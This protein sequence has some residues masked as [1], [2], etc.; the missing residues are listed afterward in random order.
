PTGPVQIGVTSWGPEVM[1]GDCGVKHLPQVP[2]RVSSFAAFINSKHPVIEPYAKRRNAVPKIVGLPHIG[3]TVTC[4][5][6]ELV[7]DGIKMSYS[8]QLAKGGK[9]VTLGG[10]HKATLAIT[11][12]LY[13][14][15]LPDRRLFC[16]AIA[17]NAGGHWSAWSGSARPHK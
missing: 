13:R 5:A 4:R 17:T 9:V 10:A 16:T 15:S 7:G 1:G 6:P 12:A 8:W 3:H 14:K 2:M 11:K